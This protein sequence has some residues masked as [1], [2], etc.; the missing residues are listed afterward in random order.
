MRHAR[1]FWTKRVSDKRYA[2]SLNSGLLELTGSTGWSTLGD[3]G[4]FFFLFV[5][6]LVEV[7]VVLEDLCIGSRAAVFQ[8]P[9]AEC[10]YV[11]ESSLSRLTDMCIRWGPIDHGT[12]PKFNRVSV[13]SQEASFRRVPKGM[14][15]PPSPCLSVL[16][17]QHQFLFPPPCPVVASLESQR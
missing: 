16:L 6:D 10:K 11:Q 2:T 14:S 8:F 1:S 9:A 17:P 12:A 15:Q 4:F 13:R 7:S 3:T 5:K